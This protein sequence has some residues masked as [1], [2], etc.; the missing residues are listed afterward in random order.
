[1]FYVYVFPYTNK[2]LYTLDLK[3]NSKVH[4]LKTSK[5]SEQR[6]SGRTLLIT[7]DV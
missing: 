4:G 5:G 3:K 7:V 6:S 1:M 2:T